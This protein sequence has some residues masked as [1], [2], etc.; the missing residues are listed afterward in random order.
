MISLQLLGQ[1]AGM[2][3]IMVLTGCIAP[4][5]T[6]LAVIKPDQ[7]L[8]PTLETITPTQIPMVTPTIAPTPVKSSGEEGIIFNKTYGGATSHNIGRFITSTR[9][10]GYLLLEESIMVAGY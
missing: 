5:G 8:T 2:V 7:T 10:G 9:D 3:L 1:F 4:T 6:P